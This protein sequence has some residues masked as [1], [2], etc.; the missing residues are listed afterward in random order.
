MTGSIA[1]ITSAAAVAV[2]SFDMRVRDPQ[3]FLDL[4]D[5]DKYDEMRSQGNPPDIELTYSEPSPIKLPSTL[6]L[7]TNGEITPTVTMITGKVQKFGDNVDT[8]MVLF[9]SPL[10]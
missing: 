3:P 7:E 10:S 4:I 2:S 5:W 1:N 9:F 8:D 6:A